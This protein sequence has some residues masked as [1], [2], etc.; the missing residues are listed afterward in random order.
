ML[1]G[2]TSQ[3]RTASRPRAPPRRATGS[4]RAAAEAC[5]WPPPAIRCEAHGDHLAVDPDREAC[6]GCCSITCSISTTSRVAPGGDAGRP[7]PCRCPRSRR[8]SAPSRPSRAP[9][10]PR[11]HG[12]GEVQ[13]RHNGRVRK[14]RRLAQPTSIRF[15]SPG[16]AIVLSNGA[17]VE[18]GVQRGELPQ[19]LHDPGRKPVVGE[20]IPSHVRPRHHSEIA[21]AHPAGQQPR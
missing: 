17:S 15:R 12:L 2:L 21:P 1:A 7:R 10:S 20:T 3:G 19:L 4:M 14:G 9:T 13:V 8:T 11:R 5:L 6:E 18:L 16:L